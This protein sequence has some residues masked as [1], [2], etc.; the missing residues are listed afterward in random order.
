M[1]DTAISSAPTIRVAGR[2][3]GDCAMCCKIPIIPELDKPYNTWCTHCSNHTNCSI[4]DTRPQ[5]CRDFFCHFMTSTLSEEWRPSKCRLIVTAHPD[6]VLVMVDP[7]RPDAWRKEP[8]FSN[9]THWSTQTSVY[10][11]LGAVTYAVF[12]DHVDALGE[13]TDDHHIMVLEEPGP[14]G[15]RKRAVR[16][17]K[18]EAPAHLP[19]PTT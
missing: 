6:R 19:R 11:M 15:P 9:I 7:A 17:L 14:H 4:Y 5:R 2:S 13:V 16:I 3:C 18:S 8:Y 10:V 1:T 12:P